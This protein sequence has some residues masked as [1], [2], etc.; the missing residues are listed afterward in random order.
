MK[1]IKGD[2]VE[3]KKLDKLLRIIYNWRLAHGIHIINELQAGGH[4]GFCGVW[5]PNAVVPKDWSWDMCDK[6]KGASIVK[7]N[8]KNLGKTLFPAKE[9]R[10]K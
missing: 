4:C 7:N 6:H 3:H 5:M 8:E 2:R 1:F 10:N 9:S